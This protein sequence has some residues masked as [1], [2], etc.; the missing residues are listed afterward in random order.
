MWEGVRCAARRELARLRRG[1][2]GFEGVALLGVGLGRGSSSLSKSS[3]S[4]SLRSR[5]ICLSARPRCFSPTPPRRCGRGGGAGAEDDLLPLPR[6]LRSWGAAMAEF[7]VG[8]RRI[9]RRSWTQCTWDW[10]VPPTLMVG[11]ACNW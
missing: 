2:T 7:D 3:E 6:P 4:E 11:F 10:S 1:R 8:L 5:W 9:S